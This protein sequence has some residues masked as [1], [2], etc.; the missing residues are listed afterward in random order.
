MKCKSPTQFQRD[1]NEVRA[2]IGII[3]AAQNFAIRDTII[4]GPDPP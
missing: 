2:R 4:D 3:R 1:P